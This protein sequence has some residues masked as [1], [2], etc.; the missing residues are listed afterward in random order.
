[1]VNININAHNKLRNIK[2][3]LGPQGECDMPNTWD[4]CVFL[5]GYPSFHKYV[6]NAWTGFTR[7][8]CVP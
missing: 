8:I 5:G 1:M 3:C 4:V 6:A 2:V 7:S